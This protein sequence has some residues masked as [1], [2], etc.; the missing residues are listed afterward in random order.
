[1]R[2]SDSSKSS[3][4]VQSTHVRIRHA[5]SKKKKTNTISLF[6]LCSEPTT[7]YQHIQLCALIGLP[8]T[9]ELVPYSVQTPRIHHFSL[10]AVL[11]RTTMYV[12]FMTANAKY[13]S[14]PYLFAVPAS[15]FCIHVYS[16]ASALPQFRLILRFT[17]ND[18]NLRSKFKPY[19]RPNIQRLLQL[20]S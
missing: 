5:A 9:R 8:V 16:S 10:H 3:S 14:Y 4:I 15:H 20:G 2:L 17:Q 7:D 6:W 13:D 19:G 1:M 18:N 11:A 12:N